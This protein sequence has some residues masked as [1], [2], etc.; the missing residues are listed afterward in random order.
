MFDTL[1]ALF[2]HLTALFTDLQPKTADF[3]GVCIL[4]LAYRRSGLLKLALIGF[5]FAFSKI[6]N[7]FHNPLSYNE[8]CSF[9]AFRKLGSFGILLFVISS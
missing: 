4:P 2:H 6:A 9:L 3:V 5:V 8:L 1:G 7:Y